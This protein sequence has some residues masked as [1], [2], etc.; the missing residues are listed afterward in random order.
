MSY[1]NTTNNKVISDYEY[2][3]L[4]FYEKDLYKEHNSSD[5]SFTDSVIIGA[6]TDSALIGGLLGGDIVGGIIGD[7]LN[8]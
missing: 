2:D 6:V 3:N 4:P 8:D 5:S 7:L 1:I